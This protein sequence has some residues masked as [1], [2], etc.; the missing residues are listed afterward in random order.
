MQRGVLPACFRTSLC[1]TALASQPCPLG[2]RCLHAH[3]LEELRAAAAV[4]LGDLPP[5]Y[6]MSICTVFQET[7][8][9]P[10]AIVLLGPYLEP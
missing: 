3:S 4:A 2:R 9:P 5:D 7:G 10:R 6:K 1:S 8:V